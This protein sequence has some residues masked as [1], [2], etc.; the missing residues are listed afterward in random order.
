MESQGLITKDEKNRI[1]NITLDNLSAATVKGLFFGGMT[2]LLFRSKM[3]GLFVL[4][5]SIGSSLSKSEEY[6]ADNLK[7]V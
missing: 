5:Y 3:V 2:G 1:V 4:S 6:L 7:Y